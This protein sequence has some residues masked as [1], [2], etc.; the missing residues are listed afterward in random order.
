[1][2]LARLIRVIDTLNLNSQTLALPIKP[3]VG[4]L[5]IA[6]TGVCGPCPTPP[7]GCRQRRMYGENVRAVKLHFCTLRLCPEALDVR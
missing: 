7:P 2:T 6:V 4:G 1:M 5:D 3:R